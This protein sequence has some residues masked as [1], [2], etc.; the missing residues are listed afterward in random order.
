MS[1]FEF[2]ADESGA[3]SVDFA[4]VTVL[5]VGLGIATLSTIGGGSANLAQD[6][7]D[8]FTGTDIT[9]VASSDVDDGTDTGGDPIGG[10]EPNDEWN[11]YPDDTT[12]DEETPTEDPVPEEPTPEEPV[13][14]EPEPDN[15]LPED[16]P[17]EEEGPYDNCILPNGKL[18]KNC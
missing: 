7:G 15:P 13:E 14:E 9:I 8:D 2:T 16:P 3:I 6:V 17:A 4:A 5:L 1:K 10:G 12:P 18:K 11:G